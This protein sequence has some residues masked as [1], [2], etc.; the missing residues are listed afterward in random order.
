MKFRIF[1]ICFLLVAQNLV[2]SVGKRNRGTAA[3]GPKIINRN[4]A[5]NQSTEAHDFSAVKFSADLYEVNKL[6]CTFNIQ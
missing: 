2:L 6:L 4:N 3:K 5:N 1:V